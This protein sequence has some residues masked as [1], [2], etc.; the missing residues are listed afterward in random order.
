MP[1][2]HMDDIM[3]CSRDGRRLFRQWDPASMHPFFFSPCPFVWCLPPG[4]TWWR[5]AIQLL[6]VALHTAGTQLAAQGGS[7]NLSPPPSAA[8]AS[9][10]LRQAT[11]VVPPR[12]YRG[13]TLWFSCALILCPALSDLLSLQYTVVEIR[14]GFASGYWHHLTCTKDNKVAAAVDQVDVGDACHWSEELDADDSD[15]LDADD[16]DSADELDVDDFDAA[17]LD[18]FLP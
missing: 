18:Y 10:N 4:P 16:F 17:D 9:F 8:P 2:I 5:M 7:L 14:D 3:R 13:S 15:E 6:P 1:L 12:R 11:Q